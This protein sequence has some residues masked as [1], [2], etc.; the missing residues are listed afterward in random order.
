MNVLVTGGSGLV[1][2]HVIDQ[3]KADHRITNLDLNAGSRTDIRQLQ[4]DVLHLPDLTKKLKGFDAVVH[5]AGIPHPLIEP[6]EKV[7]QVNVMGTFNVLEAAV[8]ND[9]RKV[10]FLSSESTLGFAFSTT[11]QW[12]EYVPVN[13]EHPL[14]PQD[15]YGVSK[16][17]GELLCAAASRRSGMQTVCL[18]APWIWVPEK[19]EVAFYQSLV[20]EYHKWEKNLWAYIHVFDVARAIQC[21]LEYMPPS[22]HDVFFICAE[23]NWTDVDSRELLARFYPETRIDRNMKNRESLISSGKARRMLRFTPAFD[24]SHLLHSGTKQ[25][26]P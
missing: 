23:D 12:P 8:R 21:S 5:L 25:K 10:V 26:H 2:R 13:E 7:F 6:P 16:V 14:R 9:I 20:D 3:L 17:A 1:G 24:R 15:A 11:R 4:G 22:G 19:K 18:R